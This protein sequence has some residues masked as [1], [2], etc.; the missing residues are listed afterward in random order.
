MWITIALLK[1]C[2]FGQRLTGKTRSAPENLLIFARRLIVNCT[3][4]GVQLIAPLPIFSGLPRDKLLVRVGHPRPIILYRQLPANYGAI[5]EALDEGRA[6]A[7]ADAK[8][9]PEAAA[10]LI[11][12]LASGDPWPAGSETPPPPRPRRAARLRL[13]E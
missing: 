4:F 7:V 1:V 9:P 13:L 2:V 8:A 6:F 3:R 12:L 10:A 11:R 5:V